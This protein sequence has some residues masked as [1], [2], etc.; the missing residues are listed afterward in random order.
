MRKV[1]NNCVEKEHKCA[2]CYQNDQ[3]YKRKEE[4]KAK[5]WEW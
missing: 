1:T 3:Y 2:T 4:R 5:R